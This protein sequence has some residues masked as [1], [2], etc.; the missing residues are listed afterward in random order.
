MSPDQGNN[1]E[2]Y[3][4]YI[5]ENCNP[6]AP[7]KGAT[8]MRD[9]LKSHYDREHALNWKI[10]PDN[11]SQGPRPGAASAYK[12]EARRRSHPE[13]RS[14]S[15]VA[16][17]PLH[18]PSKFLAMIMHG[19]LNCFGIYTILVWIIIIN[20]CRRSWLKHY[21]WWSNDITTATLYQS[22]SQLEA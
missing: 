6:F 17:A 19:L 20:I 5:Y 15:K 9:Q 18:N 21:D 2:H 7:K 16:S 12:R 14:F 11:G 3:L 10:L 4:L 8:L 22:E 13:Y 1:V